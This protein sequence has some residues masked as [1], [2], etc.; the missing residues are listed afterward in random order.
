VISLLQSSFSWLLLGLHF[1]QHTLATSR[2][3]DL[4]NHGKAHIFGW[5]GW[6]GYLAFFWLSYACSSLSALLDRASTSSWS[7]VSLKSCGNNITH[8]LTM[9]SVTVGCADPMF[10]SN[11][12]QPNSHYSSRSKER[13]S[14]NDW[15]LYP[16]VPYQC[17]R[18]LHMDPSAYANEHNVS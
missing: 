4:G 5:F 9:P 11:Y 7:S 14:V 6:N 1:L 18:V 8:L 3:E 10:T 12:H 16:H 2:Q 17:Q 15:H 13:T